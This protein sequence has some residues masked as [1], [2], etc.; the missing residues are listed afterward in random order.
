VKTHDV[1]MK[2]LYT[3]AEARNWCCEW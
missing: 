3:S 2:L 1:C